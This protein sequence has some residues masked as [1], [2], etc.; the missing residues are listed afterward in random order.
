MPAG[1]GEF[2]VGEPM[3][4]KAGRLCGNVG[5]MR[6][7]TAATREH[8]HAVQRKS[9]VAT[10]TFAF[11]IPPYLEI[12][13][14][15]SLLVIDCIRLV[16]HGYRSSKAET[17]TGFRHGTLPLRCEIF[18]VLHLNVIFVNIHI[19]DAVV[20][21]SS[22]MLSLCRYCW[23]N[24]EPR[25]WIHIDVPILHGGIP[26]GGLHVDHT[27]IVIKRLLQI[28]VFYSGCGDHR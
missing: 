2:N 5:D 23:L 18:L 20:F 28:G 9:C 13:L 24:G 21:W 12:V 10:L 4:E 3:D 19:H 6:S 17:T 11:P 27:C 26:A 1:E 15:M 22:V 8:Q 7:S 14:S 25:R 16:S